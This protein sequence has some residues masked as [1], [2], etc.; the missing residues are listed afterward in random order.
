VT[1]GP[2]PAMLT[3][4][5]LAVPTG[6][7]MRRWTRSCARSRSEASVWELFTD[8]YTA[9]LVIA[10]AVSMVLS[11]SA[12][13]GADLAGSPTPRGDGIALPPGWIGVL[14]GVAAVVASVGVMA[15]LGPVA[16]SAPEA[17]WWLPL[18]SDR[19]SLL[20]AA[21]ARWPAVALGVGSVVGLATA[22]S[23]GA[24]A[25]PTRLAASAVLAGGV[26]C[27]LVLAAGLAQARPRAHRRLRLTA[28]AALGAVPLAGVGLAVAGAATPTVPGAVV[29]AAAASLGCAAALGVALDRRLDRIRDVSLRERGV[30]AGDALDA[31]LLLDSRALGRALAER[32]EPA[33]R[34]RPRRLRW[35]RHVPVRLRPGAALVSSDALL[36]LRS[37][38]HLVQLAVCTSLPVLA[39]AVPRP[40]PA[41]VGLALLAGAYAAGLAAAEGA[42]RA[43]ARGVLDTLLP[44]SETGVRRWR[45]TV[46]VL[47]TCAW[48][49]P[50]AAC[51]AWRYGDAPGWLALALLAAPVWGAAAVRASYR[52][53]PDFTGPLV[54]TPMGA[55]PVGVTAVVVRGP[56]VA[57]VGSIPVLV[58]V[59]L[60][61]VPGVLLAVQAVLTGAA[62]AL[63][64]RPEKRPS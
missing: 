6:R 37:T 31:V 59:F 50:V 18:A 1:A 42:R 61:E 49:L 53:P 58:A 22:L 2:V 25:Q 63:S 9:A 23:L 47:A 62:L 48:S 32:S 7:A 10:I 24:A 19:R 16:V 64:A 28:D 34:R 35:L 46:P 29:P 33:V 11:A 17:T 60:A 44:L 55:V 15:R 38:R 8:L 30:V 56:D 45:L 13:L 14:L 21:A 5:P 26:T 54:S 41:V 3:S 43:A 4:D 51:L 39:V 57:L 52:P 36:L 12:G 20:R 27:T 40:H